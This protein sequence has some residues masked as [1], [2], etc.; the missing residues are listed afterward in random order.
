MNRFAILVL[1]ACILFGFL[2]SLF[3]QLVVIPV[4]SVDQSALVPELAS[5]ATL[6]AA[7]AIAVVACVQVALI[8]VWMLLSMAESD[9]LFTKRAFLWVDVVIGAAVVATLLTAGVAAH[10]FTVEVGEPT[11]FLFLYLVAIVFVGAIFVLLMIVM[12]GVLGKATAIEGE[13][14]EVV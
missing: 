3:G 6:Y 7:L 13:L 8:A 2:G 12:R 4:Q 9:A 5:V 10:F 14:A 1:R 11:V